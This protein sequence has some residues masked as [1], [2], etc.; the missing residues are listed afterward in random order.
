M[1]IVMTIGT[2]PY[3]PPFYT[4]LASV[5]PLPGNLLHQTPP[6]QEWGFIWEIACTYLYI[7]GPLSFNLGNNM[8]EV[9][10]DVDSSLWRS[11][12]VAEPTQISQNIMNR[13]DFYSSLILSFKCQ[14][15]KMLFLIFQL[16]SLITLIISKLLHTCFLFAFSIQVLLHIAPLWARY[17]YPQP[18]LMWPLGL[19]A[20]KDVNRVLYF[21]IK[22][23]N[24]FRLN[25]N[26][27]VWWYLCPCC[28][29]FISCILSLLFCLST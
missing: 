26:D 25:K 21:S 2:S 5:R 15:S 20:Q 6:L 1:T 19:G 22:I 28:H 12:T 7:T 14:A 23:N 4:L 17:Q 9:F 8:P 18:P 10:A 11:P 16:L 27:M 13:W 24:H 3:V 29:P